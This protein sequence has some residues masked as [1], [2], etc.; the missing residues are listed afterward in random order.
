MGPPQ[1][2]LFLVAL[3]LHGGEHLG[4]CR[5]KRLTVGE[6]AIDQRL[7]PLSDRNGK[8]SF[9]D[10][11][12]LLPEFEPGGFARVER[13]RPVIPLSQFLLVDN[14]PACC[15]FIVRPEEVRNVMARD[16]L[17]LVSPG[18][19]FLLQEG[20]TAFYGPTNLAFAVKRFRSR[21]PSQTLAEEH[22]RE[23]NNH[24]DLEM[25]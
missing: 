23:N 18:P 24:A 16:T 12:F 9:Q 8:R 22:T 15:G 6:A 17:P 25:L 3:H 20:K 4:D 13:Q 5:R 14:E 1:Q 10:A 2:N 21:L 19:P 11:Q 7:E